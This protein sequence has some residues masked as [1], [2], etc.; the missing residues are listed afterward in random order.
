MGE[1]ST[2][3]V[4]SE[5]LSLVTWKNNAQEPQQL[6]IR[7][8]LVRPYT[9]PILYQ[10]LQPSSSS[11]TPTVSQQQTTQLEAS[12]LITP[13]P[14]IDPN[15]LRYSSYLFSNYYP[16]SPTLA[17]TL[18][19]TPAPTLP[20]QSPE[21]MQYYAALHVEYLRSLMALGPYPRM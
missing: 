3:P 1:P 7:R 2:S 11:S 13:I 14:P 4:Q 9:S 8:D 10:S 17:P 19:P 5:P 16:Y 6:Q 21:M 18:S 15:I 12:P 20:Y